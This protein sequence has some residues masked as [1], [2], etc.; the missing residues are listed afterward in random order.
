MPP[1]FFMGGKIMSETAKDHRWMHHEAFRDEVLIVEGEPV[2]HVYPNKDRGGYTLATRPFGGWFSDHPVQHFETQA[3]AKGMGNVHGWRYQAESR[4]AH[5]EMAKHFELRDRL[6]NA[7]EWAAP[8]P[9]S[10]PRQDQ[11][12]DQEL[13]R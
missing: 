5:D 3:Y 11:E 10:D 9:Q 2:A 8:S 13:D 6:S 4:R 1:G 7:W 12:P